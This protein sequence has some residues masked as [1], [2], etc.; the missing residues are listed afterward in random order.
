VDFGPIFENVLYSV[1]LAV[2]RIY[3]YCRIAVALEF[4]SIVGTGQSGFQ[5]FI[6]VVAIGNQPTLE[7]IPP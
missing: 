4:G 3:R 2:D 7:K 5:P 6:Q 1:Y